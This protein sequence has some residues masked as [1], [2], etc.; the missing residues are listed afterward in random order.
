MEVN[1]NAVE[2]EIS[3]SHVSCLSISLLK[4]CDASQPLD[5]LERWEWLWKLAPYNGSSVSTQ[6]SEAGSKEAN[7]ERMIQPCRFIASHSGNAGFKKR[8]R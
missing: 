8:F 1:Y 6:C 2:T 3:L 5:Q 7:N 4:R